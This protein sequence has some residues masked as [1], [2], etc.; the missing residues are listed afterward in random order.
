M[1]SYRALFL[2]VLSIWFKGV[3][4]Q[5]SEILQFNETTFDF[6]TIKEE[7]RFAE[8]EFLFTNVSPEPIKILRVTA[9]CGCTTPGWSQDTIASGETGFIKARYSTSNRPGPFNKN[10]TVMVAGS[11]KPIRLF[12]KGVVKPQPKTVAEKYPVSIGDLGFEM[13]IFNLGMVK[14]TDSATVASFKIYNHGL[15]DLTFKDLIETPSHI[16][17]EFSTPVLKSKEE[18]E[19][20]L[21]YDAK[22]LNDYGFMNHNITFYT[23]EEVNP[24]KAISVYATVQEYFPPM[25]AE[26]LKNAP[27]ISLSKTNHDFGTLKAG[28]ESEVTL[29]ITNNGKEPL[30]IRKVASNCDCLLGI[31][32][33]EKIKPGKSADLLIRLNTTDRQG[34]QNKS[35]SIIN[36]D[37]KKPVI[38][39]MVQANV[40]EN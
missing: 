12:I 1:S 2:I 26:E 21:H 7:D 38:R 40:S 23:D 20:I 39:V 11:G 15:K 3:Y 18:G 16:S 24:M 28:A 29:Q 17:M 6:G 10:L 13:K 9:S 5:S 8:H 27:S 32:K 33:K 19:I 35:L 25:T 22:G 14:T 34:N 36:N 30:I 37:P 31:V 4:G